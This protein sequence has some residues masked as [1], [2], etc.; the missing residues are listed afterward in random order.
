MKTPFQLRSKY[1]LA[2][3]LA[4]LASLIL[5]ATA[6]ATCILSIEPVRDQ[7]LMRVNPLETS[8]ARDRIEVRV[9]NKGDTACAGS[10]ETALQGDI[11]GLRANEKAQSI[12]Y[13]LIDDRNQ[14]DITPRAGTSL[15]GLSNGQIHLAPGERS[16]ELISVY[17]T[18]SELASQGLYTQ[19][20]E[21]SVVGPDGIALG[22]KPILIG[23]EIVPSAIIG[24][25][26]AARRSDS[27]VEVNLGELTPG[28][29]NLPLTLYVHSTGGYRVSVSSEN[30]GRLKHQSSAWFVPYDLTMGRHR[31]RLSAPDG[32]EVPSQQARFDDYP[33]EVEISETEGKR[34]GSYRDTVTFTVATL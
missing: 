23:V 29:K 25:K 14:S 11:F 18:P 24:I 2:S 32:F 13:Q 27:G 17:I 7:I 3:I 5:P 8:A 33:L 4:I 16:L 19:L 34:A 31:L 21:L 12:A 6:H 28:R 10:L 30:G 20:V 15:T 22:T 9:F 1:Y 26:G